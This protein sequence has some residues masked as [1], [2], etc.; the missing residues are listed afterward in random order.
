MYA[1]YSAV[2]TAGFNAFL[3]SFFAHFYTRTHTRPFNG[4]LSGT[5]QVSRYQKGK[6][7]LDFTEPR[8]SEWQWHQLA[9]C[10]SAPHSTEITTPAPLHSVFYGPDA[11]PVAQPTASE[12]WRH[13][14]S[15]LISVK[16][17]KRKKACWKDGSK[18]TCREFVE[19]STELC[20]SVVALF[21][22]CSWCRMKLRRQETVT[23]SRW[24]PINRLHQLSSVMVARRHRHL[25]LSSHQAA[26][27]MMRLPTDTGEAPEAVL[28]Q[29]L[30]FWTPFLITMLKLVIVSLYTKFVHSLLCSM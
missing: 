13:I 29:S 16:W 3:S 25:Q 6:T 24:M 15:F 30:R 14:C 27:A 26:S 22:C 10:N 8:S 1:R 21:E 4:L 9:I 28:T 19:F 17:L 18:L 20:S 7:N 11:L 2:A 23:L 12:H 5:T